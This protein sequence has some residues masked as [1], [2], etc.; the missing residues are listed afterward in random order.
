MN[1]VNMKNSNE[2]FWFSSGKNRLLGFLSFIITVARQ[3]LQNTLWT[4]FT[5]FCMDFFFLD[6]LKANWLQIL[7]IASVFFPHSFLLKANF[8]FQ[9]K[10]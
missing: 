5:Y 8:F 4:F 1:S 10:H 9:C 6:S 2:R 7:D 3:I